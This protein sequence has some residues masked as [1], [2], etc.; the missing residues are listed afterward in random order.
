M[1]CRLD[2]VIAYRL[3]RGIGFLIAV[4]S[5]MFLSGVAVAEPRIAR[6][7]RAPYIPDGYELRLTQDCSIRPVGRQGT[8]GAILDCAPGLGWRLH[9]SNGE[10]IYP[11]SGYLREDARWVFLTETRALFRGA[12]LEVVD[13]PSGFRHPLPYRDMEDLSKVDGLGLR[14]IVWRSAENADEP[15]PAFVLEDD[16]KIGPVL[17]GSDMRLLTIPPSY[18][19]RREGV[20]A[21]IGVERL[22]NSVWSALVRRASA[23]G[24]ERSCQSS[25][26]DRLAGR[27]ADGAWRA[28]SPASLTPLSEERFSDSGAALGLSV[29][30][31]R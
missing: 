5:A 28:L 23:G 26:E 4:V 11:K 16:G 9:S 8:P 19:C 14:V 31:L 21:A 27:G 29:D 18:N 13:L 15:V 2:Q 1:C 12:S 17:P 22:P 7:I 20:L 3:S 24:A 30:Q 6:V 10:L 25:L